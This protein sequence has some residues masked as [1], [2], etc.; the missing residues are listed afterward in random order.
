M[1]TTTAFLR[2]GATALAVACLC[3]APAA[4][5]QVV[6]EP[7][8]VTARRANIDWLEAPMAVGVARSED[9]RAEQNLA[10]DE[11]LD[12]VPGVVTQNRYNLA[13]GLRLSVRGFGARAGF[14]VR[15]VRV[16]VDGVPLTMPDGQTELDSIDLD[17]VDQLEVI[18][19]PASTLYGNAAGGVLLVSTREPPEDLSAGINLRAGGDGYRQYSGEIGGGNESVRGLAGLNALRLDG[20]RD[21][22]EAETNTF[23]GKLVVPGSAGRLT[24]MLSAIDNELQDPGGLNAAEVAADRTQAAPNNLRYD[25]GEAVEQQRLSLAWDGRATERSD[26]RLGLYAGRRTFENRLPFLDGGQGAYDRDFGGFTAQ[27]THRADWLGVRHQATVGFDLE[28][29]RDDRRRYDNL[30]GARGALTLDQDESADSSGVFLHDAIYLGRDWLAELG[31]RYDRIRLEV[32]DQFLTDGDDSGSRRLSDWSWSAGVSYRLNPNL[33][34]FGRV[35]TSFETPTI[36]ELANPAGGGFNPALDPAEALNREL[37]LKGEWTRLRYEFVLFSVEVEDE[38]V[39]YELPGQSGRSFYRN[40]GESRRDGVE[41]SAD[42]RLNDSWRLA[43]AY[44]YSDFQ[45]E[46]YT[47][48][49]IDYAGNELPGIPRQQLI[50]EIG[51]SRGGWHAGLNASVFDRMYADDANDVRIAGYTVA[52]LRVAY[53]YAR[54]ALTWEPYAG[55]NNLFDKEYFG[56]IRNN[57]GFGRYYEPAPE[58]NFYAG[59]R[60]SY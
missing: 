22:G 15:G 26:Y 38:L 39:R 47:L 12:I 60:V 28:A 19:G 14:G 43:A 56:N 20:Y 18:R 50:T 48:N 27:Y 29:Q 8:V 59:L 34:A 2:R 9:S 45:F 37:G 13:Q 41:I 6:I 10:L 3:A 35:A 31:L 16:L 21:H 57:A 23:T 40:A 11:L 52:N 58:R 5:Q 32:D 42:W 30:D 46:R 33:R 4:A 54:G 1:T 7:I 25:A 49:G 55:V 44:T 17:L 53:R 24:A 36:N 51:Y